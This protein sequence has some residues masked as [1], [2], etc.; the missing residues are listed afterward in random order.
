M[1]ADGDGGAAK[2]W[3]FGVLNDDGVGDAEKPGMQ[4]VLRIGDAVKPGMLTVSGISDAA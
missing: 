3:C 2:L 1:D 4:M